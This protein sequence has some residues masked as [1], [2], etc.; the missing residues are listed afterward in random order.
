MINEKRTNTML[1]MLLLRI[2]S[3]LWSIYFLFKE[4]SGFKNNDSGSD[5]DWGWKM[6]LLKAL[7]DTNRYFYYF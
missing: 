6:D 2:K 3:L 4:D 5:D 7:Y 1:K